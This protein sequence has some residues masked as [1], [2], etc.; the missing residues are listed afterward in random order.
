MLANAS[1]SLMCSC[2]I[3]VGHSGRTVLGFPGLKYIKFAN[4]SIIHF[5]ILPT[6]SLKVYFVAHVKRITSKCIMFSILLK[7]FFVRASGRL[8]R[9]EHHVLHERSCMHVISLMPFGR[10]SLHAIPLKVF[11][12][13]CSLHLNDG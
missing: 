6:M 13:S 7:F 12:R 9:W 8:S 4:I 11:D 3:Y 5:P 10:S 2:V 1:F